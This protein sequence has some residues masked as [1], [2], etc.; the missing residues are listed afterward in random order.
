MKYTAV[1]VDNGE[2]TLVNGSDHVTNNFTFSEYA[3]KDGSH[4]ILYSKRLASLIQAIR[5]TVGPVTI[6]SAFRTPEHNDAVG[7]VADSQHLL[8]IAVDL[9][10]PYGYNA[11]SFMSA[12]EK[13]T[14]T[15]VGLGKYRTFIHLDIRG[16]K[17]RWNG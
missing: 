14:G 11:D 9:K 17:A 4:V 15:E 3:S 13:I 6:N 16:Y 8:G 12:I 10:I 7:G 2:I 5:D 1:N